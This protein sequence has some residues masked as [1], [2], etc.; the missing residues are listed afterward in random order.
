MITTGTYR[1]RVEPR[2]DMLAAYSALDHG[3]TAGLTVPQVDAAYARL[4]ARLVVLLFLHG[5]VVPAAFLDALSAAEDA[6][7][8]EVTAAFLETGGRPDSQRPASE[9]QQELVHFSRIVDLGAAGLADEE[10]EVGRLLRRLRGS[11]RLPQDLKVLSELVIVTRSRMLARGRAL[12]V[13]LLRAG[14][15]SGEDITEHASLWR[16]GDYSL[17]AASARRRTRKEAGYLFTALLCYLTP[18]EAALAVWAH[19]AQSV[20]R[21]PL[22]V[23]LVDAGQAGTV[24]EVRWSIPAGG[25]GWLGR[26]PVT[27]CRGQLPVVT[28]TARPR[29]SWREVPGGVVMALS[30]G[31]GGQLNVTLSDE[32]RSASHSLALRPVCNGAVPVERMAERAARLLSTYD[33]PD[34]AS[35][36]CGHIHLDRDLD[37]DQATGA[38]L[39]ARALAVL[40]GQ[41]RRAPVLTPMM[42]DD[43]VLV[44]LRPRDYRTFLER[45]FAG[46]GM[47]LVPESSPIVRAVVTVLWQRLHRLGLM[48]RLRQRGGNLFLRLGNGGEFCELFEDYQRDGQPGPAATGCVFF[49][50]ALLVYRSAPQRFDGYFRDRFGLGAGA[51]ERA[52]EILSGL[53][54]HDDRQD[55][56]ARFYA[57]FSAV[58][59]P[60]RPDPDVVAVVD[61]VLVGLGDGVA[62]LNVLEDYYEVQQGK[63]RA[64]LRLLELPIRLITVH[65]NVQTGRVVLDG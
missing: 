17:L 52:A 47:Q 19:A 64:L 23:L 12:P 32:E 49:E 25:S 16:A 61:D 26:D 4:L 6:D 48:G 1:G 20:L 35:I 45:W 15:A 29:P 28:A 50:S 46:S 11:H 33:G 5:P 42:D 62:H 40:A 59:D 30:P 37:A 7:P 10:P 38:R 2:R 56:L 27:W 63:V 18:V 31:P 34:V 9:L 58:T 41:Q 24:T 39:G 44:R 21:A 43:H 13:P 57:R 36:E 60:R 51:H 55:R 14:A 22:E 8:V 3:T 54:G 65:F 53:G